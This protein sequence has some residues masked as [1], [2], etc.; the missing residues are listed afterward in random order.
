MSYRQLT[1]A[2]RWRASNGSPRLSTR[3][4]LE[5]SQQ[6]YILDLAHARVRHTCKHVRD[7][8]WGGS[9]ISW[10]T[11]VLPGVEPTQ[12]HLAHYHRIEGVGARKEHQ[13]GGG[14]TG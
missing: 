8:S 5:C 1:D 4:K 7:C 11:V 10:T 13:W 14:G 12:S 3:S 2:G 6:I 9:G